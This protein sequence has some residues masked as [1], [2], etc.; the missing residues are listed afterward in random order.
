MLP[1]DLVDRSATVVDA[2][3]MLNHPQESVERTSF[4]TIEKR[5]HVLPNVYR[6]SSNG[7]DAVAEPEQARPGATDGR[8]RAHVAGWRLST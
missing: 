2:S 8:D 7:P 6:T 5:H 3:E 1:P 4:E